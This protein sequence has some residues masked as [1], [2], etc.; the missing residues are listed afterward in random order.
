MKKVKKGYKNMSYAEQNLKYKSLKQMMQSLLLEDNK[1]IQISNKVTVRPKKKLC[2]LTGL[3][4][5]YTCPT[6]GLNYYDS[7]VYKIINELS[8]DRVKRLFELKEFGISQ[9]PFKK[10]K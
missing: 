1:Y 3:P 10:T 6:T 4:S 2:D 9:I 5:F 7:S 8:S